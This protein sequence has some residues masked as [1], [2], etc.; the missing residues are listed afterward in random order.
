[1]E[2]GKLMLIVQLINSLELNY[3]SLSNAYNNSDKQK[4]DSSNLAILEIHK[5]INSVLNSL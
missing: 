3:N 5:K 2:Q 4:F 1:M